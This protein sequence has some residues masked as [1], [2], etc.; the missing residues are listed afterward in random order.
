V[1]Q[2]WTTS[3]NIP[4]EK[5]WTPWTTDNCQYMGGYITKYLDDFNFVTIRGAGHM[6]PNNKPY[7][8]FEMMNN[9]FSGKEFKAYNASC[10]SPPLN[11]GVFS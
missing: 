5:D 11:Q 9:F 7:L 8:A 1:A 3:L 2:N 4:L 10:V 6:V